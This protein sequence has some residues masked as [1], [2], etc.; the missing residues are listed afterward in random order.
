MIGELIGPKRGKGRGSRAL[1]SLKEEFAE[2]VEPKLVALLVGEQA[3]DPSG[4]NKEGKLELQKFLENF[5]AKDQK[6][7][8]VGD[9][10]RLSTF[11]FP[12]EVL[13]LRVID[14]Q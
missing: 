5:L 11:F 7:F 10:V 4:R 12:K 8:S 14:L 9:L 1:E 13:A 3:I 6:A 2:K